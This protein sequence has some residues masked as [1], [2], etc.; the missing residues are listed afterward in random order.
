MTHSEH[1]CCADLTSR[2]LHHQKYA[3]VVFMILG[4]SIGLPMVGYCQAHHA[5]GV[6]PKAF[7]EYFRPIPVSGKLSKEVWGAAT[8]GPRDP[9]NGL[10]D[11]T[12]K[13]WDYWDG[14]ILRGPGRQIPDVC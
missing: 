4:L 9:T 8:V 12:M 13:H 6:D 11:T 5:A 7:I 3:S 1:R 14:K 2:T 10:E